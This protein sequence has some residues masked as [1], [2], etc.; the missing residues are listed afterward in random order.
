M[1]ITTIIAKAINAPTPLKRGSCQNLGLGGVT[2][3][4]AMESIKMATTSVD[5][6]TG[7]GE[8]VAYKAPCRLATTANI[9]LSGLQTIDG[10]VVAAND[11]V[12][13]KDQPDA[14]YHGIYI[15]SSGLWSRA[16]DFDSNRDISSGTQIFVTAGALNARS[17]WSI[18]TTNPIIVGT[19]DIV[20]E[21][22]ELVNA[23]QLEAL[24][25]SAT[26]AADTAGAAETAAEAARDD[27]IAAAASLNLPTIVADTMLVAKPDA[28]GYL[29]KAKADVR[30]F[31]DTAPY[32][33]TNTALA[34]LDQ[35]KDT[36]AQFDGSLWTFSSSNLSSL[37]TV[38]TR[39]AYYV[40]PATDTTG[41]SGAWVRN[42]RNLDIE[43]ELLGAVADSTGVGT[44]TNNATAISAAFTL[45]KFIGMNVV[46][47]PGAFRSST[48]ITYDKS[49]INGDTGFVPSIR[50]QGAALT[51]LYF[52]AGVDGL[53]VVGS[54]TGGILGSFLSISDMDLVSSGKTKSG[55]SVDKIAFLS[56]HRVRCTGWSVGLK[57]TDTIS[58]ILEQPFLNGNIT[59]LTASPGTASIPPNAI[60]MLQPWLSGNDRIGAKITNPATFAIRGGSVEGNGK[61]TAGADPNNSGGISIINPG[62]G[63]NVGVVSDGVYYEDNAG[64]TDILIFNDAAA[65]FPCSHSITGNSFTRL[66]ATSFTTYN[67]YLIGGD[68]AQTLHWSGNGFGKLSSAYVESSARPYVFCDDVNNVITLDEGAGNNYA[69][70]VAKPDFSSRYTFGQKNMAQALGY[71]FAGALSTGSTN[72]AS[73]AKLSTGRYKITLKRGW[74]GFKAIS[75]SPTLLRAVNVFTFDDT[76]ITIDLY[77]IGTTPA[78]ADADFGFAVFRPM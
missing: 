44:G 66:S 36:R 27:A 61:V 5:Q 39:K 35:T 4:F 19:T 20:I 2:L 51:R 21:Q 17:G 76:S 54:A 34:A 41:A 8:T 55:L 57:M 3:F 11:R 23:A 38:D 68:A 67:I 74:V 56:L 64:L 65:D 62:M 10:V 72:V 58:S 9:A 60:T 32:V 30:D 78:V 31:L 50:G 46:F 22:S 45:A 40:A 77:T 48:A 69:A 63:G 52:D 49:A 1:A 29:A 15:A 47:G 12:L 33:A 71:S 37:V 26:A 25:A 59:G 24:A 43:V 6:V 14:R 28:T 73:V 75:V 18:T 16:R 42:R 13:V 70:A 7:Y 53:S